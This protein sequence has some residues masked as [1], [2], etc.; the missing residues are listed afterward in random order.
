MSSSSSKKKRS[1]GGSDAFA[2]MMGKGATTKGTGSGSKKR[3]R[4]TT[5][6][7]AAASS[8]SP[9]GTGSGSRYIECPACLRN[10]IFERLNAHLDSG[11]ISNL[12]SPPRKKSSDAVA[13]STASDEPIGDASG[14]DT[15]N[16]G[17]DATT[18]L[19]PEEDT[20]IHG[21]SHGPKSSEP[22]SSLAGT[23]QHEGKQSPNKNHLISQS[24]ANSETSPSL[25]AT[26]PPTMSPAP[27]DAPKTPILAKNDNNPKAETD[28]IK[29]NVSE[30]TKSKSERK[31]KMT[32]D[33]SN[34]GG[35]IFAKMMARSQE[36]F[37]TKSLVTHYFHLHDAN[38]KVT[39][40]DTKRNCNRGGINSYWG[41]DTSADPDATMQGGDDISG[42]GAP[43][44]SGESTNE[45]LKSVFSETIRIRPIK[46]KQCVDMLTHDKD[47]DLVVSSSVPS[48]A[49]SK[50]RG[51]G[52]VNRHSRLSVPVLKS[53][54]QKN[55]RRRRPLP[56]VRVAMELADKSYGDLVRRLPIMV[57]EDSILHPDF[58]LLV[59]LMVAES[60]GFK[61][62][63]PLM[64]KLMRMVFEIASCP[65]RDPLPPDDEST[66][67]FV[68][69]DETDADLTEA[70]GQD[71]EMMLR[72]MLLRVSYGGMKCDTEML[73]R[74][75]HLWRKR[76]HSQM[77]GPDI[78]ALHTQ[79][80][81]ALSQAKSKDEA[82][83]SISSKKMGAT[84]R[85]ALSGGDP[86]QV[87]WSDLPAHSHEKAAV[88][89]GSH[90]PNLI[91]ARLEKLS[92]SDAIHNG[93]DFHCSAVLNTVL[94]D[95]SIAAAV[96][97]R[98]DGINV[99]KG[100][101]DMAEAV[102]NIAKTCMWRYSS[103]VNHKRDLS[104]MV[105]GAASNKNMDDDKPLK[106]LW[107]DLLSK[108][109][110]DYTSRYVSSRLIL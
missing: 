12:P 35:G 62:T 106:A 74:Y 38:G 14:H 59:W 32:K 9:M 49:L 87:L 41:D 17:T 27:T 86:I 69:G 26:N 42:G 81:E 102:M 71:C 93:V 98:M 22:S 8:T 15:A 54:L 96:A 85:I 34:A 110:K 6:A 31:I 19:I 77:E 57:L 73:I 72:A 51:F 68:G 56:A 37:A 4:A 46:A 53:M 70:L 39:W 83:A 64:I 60:K 18:S 78:V 88:Q 24:K 82:G 2:L 76:F 21:E 95:G 104:T 90:V 99:S 47:I 66:E 29:R 28:S 97:Q 101:E 89:S 48:A 16:T 11:C 5:S 67:A 105:D 13:T 36:V 44:I 55:I 75:E 3:R 103:G 1:S 43:F 92:P 10:V 63:Q 65:I 109:A 58:P 79:D 91:A 7:S 107:D 40:T 52:L 45:Y 94:S 100:G 61:P 25:S 23:E 84:V 80:P 20:G 33:N 108:P 30:S 50:E